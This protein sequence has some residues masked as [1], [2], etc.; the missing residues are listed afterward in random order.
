MKHA[1]D[2]TVYGR[3]QQRGSK[4]PVRKRDGSVLLKSGNVILKDSNDKSVEWMRAVSDV[5]G[6][7][8]EGRPLLTAPVVLSATFYFKRPKLHYRTAKGREH[9]LKDSAPF[10]HAQSPDVAKLVRSLEDALTGVVW[11]DDKLVYMY[12]V[13][14]R[15]WTTESERTEVLITWIE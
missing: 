12:R 3:A 4:V 14:R 1:L 13:I 8:W 7:C 15:A 10:Y 9:E 5:A 6:R 2:F 11:S